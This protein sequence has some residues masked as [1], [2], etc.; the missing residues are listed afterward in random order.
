VV[1]HLLLLLLSCHSAYD[2]DVIRRVYEYAIKAFESVL[3]TGA[4]AN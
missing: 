2:V 4:I 1:R 3:N